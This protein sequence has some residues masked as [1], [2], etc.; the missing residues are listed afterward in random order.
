MP[1]GQRAQ[2]GP[3]GGG[4]PR[5]EAAGAARKR[6]VTP[7]Q[8]L[9]LQRLVGNRATTALAAP[10]RR[11]D[12]RTSAEAWFAL[13]HP[14]AALAIYDAEQA[15]EAV[16][17]STSS[18]AVRFSVNLRNDRQTAVSPDGLSE[19]AQHEGSEV[20]AMRHV[21]WNAFNTRAFGA[22]IAEQAANAHEDDPDAIAG[23][24][25]ATQ[26]FNSLSDA[27]QAADLRNNI[28]GRDLA[29]GSF[30]YHHD[31]ADAALLAFRNTGFWIAQRQ[32]N[33]TY[34]TVRHQI[35]TAAYAG[36]ARKLANL[37]DIGLTPAGQAR[38]QA[39][40]DRE[41]QDVLA[42]PGD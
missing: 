40:R 26:L 9:T 1:A 35:S 6:A 22:D 4:W 42:F 24:D 31:V 33:G 27:D 11:L 34:K 16:I 13:Q 39:A 8:A 38:W 12:R 36:A 23:Q 29:S 2:S 19:N 37:N 32:G 18:L 21:L 41:L 5:P 15:A 3:D 10:T 30:H 7:T 25:A 17:P 20:N 28:I 14:F